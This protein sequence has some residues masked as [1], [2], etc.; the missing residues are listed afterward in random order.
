MQHAVVEAQVLQL[1]V[2][3]RRR[4]GDGL[5]IDAVHG[6]LATRHVGEVRERAVIR[7]HPAPEERRLRARVRGPV[8]FRLGGEAHLASGLLGQPAAERLRLFV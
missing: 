2:E 7:V 8:P 6:E 1:P 4:V 5:G 3:V